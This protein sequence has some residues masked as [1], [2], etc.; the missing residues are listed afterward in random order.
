MCVNN[1]KGGT[2]F[3]C[4]S[5]IIELK[6]NALGG[7]KFMIKISGVRGFTEFVVHYATYI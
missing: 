7:R 3:V 2:L 4:Q 6:R 5:R 1:I